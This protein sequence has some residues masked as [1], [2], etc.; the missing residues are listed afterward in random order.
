MHPLDSLVILLYFMGLSL[1]IWRVSR[2]PGSSA[3]DFLSAHHDLPWWA[4]C[5]SLVATETSTLTFISIP[6]IGYTQGLVFLGVA[7]GYAIGRSAVAL[8]FLP[9]YAS[10]TM[11]SAY[12]LL[13]ARYGA[14][15]QRLAS[16]AFLITR[17]LA[18]SIRLLAGALPIVWLLAQSGLPLGR[19]T[20]LG[21]ILVFTLAYT[22]LG[23][24]R[25]VV[26]SDAIQL[27]VY[28]FG[29]VFCVAFL[30][31]TLTGAG[32]HGA[33]QAGL[34]RLFHP[35][36][37]ANWLSDPFT[38]G[39]ALI[40][41]A[42]LSLAS[43]GTDQLMVQRVLA[44]RSLTAARMALIGS[45]VVVAVLFGLLSLLGVQLWVSRAGQSLAAQ[46]LASPDALFPHFMIESLPAGIAGLLIAGVLSAT[47]GSL[48]STLNAMAGAS[49]TD[50]GAVP[51]ELVERG[52]RAL[53]YRPGPLS[54]PR[55]MT[56][57][58][59]GV[60][61]L[62]AALFTMGSKSAVILGL[63]VAGWSYGPTLGAFL[64]ALFLP[65]L[66]TRA[67]MTG[68]VVSLGVMA[69]VLIVGQLG[70]PAIAF[71]WLVPLG[72]LIH[73]GAAGLARLIT[74][75]PGTAHLISQPSS[76]PESRRD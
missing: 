55:F 68:F 30:A 47:M 69:L 73:L 33:A 10:G 62:G 11:T 46:G 70:G 75:A 4:L 34:L 25:A 44:A 41:G 22:T 59:G 8:W 40:G 28:G 42:I 66:G 7:G 67:V 45:A 23:G 39:A 19:W 3:S 43:H 48:S 64:S 74:Q 21:M 53:G 12:A 6:G 61:L 31:P 13:G 27:G 9:R 54:A 65:G 60:L 5:L 37:S 38:M 24:L 2:A 14:P 29:A 15:M 18:E 58:W 63:T 35:T 32:W 56:L 51:R 71:S 57:F 50:F 20:V 1:L 26:W 16:G 72:I 36:T 49:L 52:M 76:R 17:F